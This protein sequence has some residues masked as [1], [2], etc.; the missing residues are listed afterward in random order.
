MVREP[1]WLL[2]NSHVSDFSRGLEDWSVFGTKGVNVVA[3]S[4]L[5]GAQALEIR[6]THEAW[7]AAA[8]WNFPAGPQGTL[9]VKLLL[10]PGF[11]GL[12]IGITDHFSVPFDSEDHF[13]NLFNLSIPAGG[14]IAEGTTLVEGRWHTL[15]LG[16]DCD[17]RQCRVVVNGRQV[18]IAPLLRE[19][20][21]A[22]YLRLRSTARGIDTAGFVVE[23]VEAALSG[24]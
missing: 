23:R 15:E 8:V 22:S 19:S 3:H 11:A 4:R 18:R 20:Q 24:P 10:N 13:H 21:G 1:E 9:R 5:P 12:Q 7:P 6:K 2:A 17:K 16:W 14:T